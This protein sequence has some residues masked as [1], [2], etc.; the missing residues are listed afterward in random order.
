MA[1]QAAVHC[2]AQHG[3]WGWPGTNQ[4]AG[5]LSSILLIS[6]VSGVQSV[7]KIY[8]YY[9]KFGYKTIVMGASFRNVGQITGLAGCDYLTISWVFVFKFIFICSCNV[10]SNTRFRKNFSTLNESCRKVSIVSD[11][12]DTRKYS[13]ASCQVTPVWEGNWNVS[14]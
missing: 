3:C 8:N 2:R 6:F 13:Q 4:I 14:E 11:V 12:H 5:R 1:N 7:T 10:S 9:K